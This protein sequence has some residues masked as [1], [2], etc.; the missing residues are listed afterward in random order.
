VNTVEEIVVAGKID[1]GSVEYF[2][3]ANTHEV[4]F[5]GLTPYNF[6]R[7]YDRHGEKLNLIAGYFEKRL[8]K[9]REIEL[10]I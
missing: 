10:A 2:V 6:S 5:Y 8:Q 9:L 3:D 4:F 7:Q 1:V